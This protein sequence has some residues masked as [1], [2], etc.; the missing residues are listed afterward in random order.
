MC[1]FANKPLK[2]NTI[3]AKINTLQ[4]AVTTMQGRFSR[5]D[6]VYFQSRYSGGECVGVR[7]DKP[8]KGPW[9]E[10]QRQSR[11]A[12]TAAKLRAG[13]LS[14]TDPEQFATL[15]RKFK[16]QRT[17]KTLQGYVFAWCYY[18]PAEEDGEGE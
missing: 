9:T 8:Y 5:N 4:P 12:F 3:M 11:D 7:L 16:T 13:Q 14:T 6:K 10:Q 15:Q 2:D 1:N 17:Y 18:H